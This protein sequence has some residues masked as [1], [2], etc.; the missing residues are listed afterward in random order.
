MVLDERGVAPA[1]RSVPAQERDEAL[2]V[3]ERRRACLAEADERRIEVDVLRDPGDG[4]T[5]GD[6]RPGDDERHA[7]VRLERGQLARHQTV[8]AQVESVVGAEEDVGVVGHAVALEPCLELRDQ[9]VDCL[10]R[11]RTRAICGV[12]QIER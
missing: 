12:V 10:H 7:D 6:V 9:I 3:D 8:L 2:P 4:P 5:R 11:L 1:G